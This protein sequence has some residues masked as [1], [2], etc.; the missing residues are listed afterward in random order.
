M[1]RALTLCHLVSQ[2]ANPQTISFA[3]F[4]L[5]KFN[6]CQLVWCQILVNL[7]I[8][9]Q[10]FAQNLWQSFNERKPK[11]SCLCGR[12]RQKSAATVLHACVTSQTMHNAVSLLSKNKAVFLHLQ[13]A[14]AALGHPFLQLIGF[15]QG[16]NI[17]HSHQT[18]PM[19]PGRT[20]V[21]VHH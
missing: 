7:R 2:R 20:I 6:R 16:A 9:N 18:K 8:T 15:F 12:V 10:L 17:P 19:I 1:F 5:W 13:W 14:H 11:N 21:V 3:I 4:L